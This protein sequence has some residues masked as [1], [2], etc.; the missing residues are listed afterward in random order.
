MTLSNVHNRETGKKA[1]VVFIL[2]LFVSLFLSKAMAQPGAIRRLQN[3]GGGFGGGGKGDSLQKRKDDSITINF[4]FLDSSRLQKFDSSI[5]DF[6]AKINMPWHYV[7][8]GNLGNA[9]HSLIFSPLMKSGWDHGFHSYDPYNFTVEGTRF[10]TT[11]SQYTELNYLIGARMEQNIALLH[12]QNIQPNWNAS[13]QYRLMN[14]PGFFMNQAVNHNNYR[15]G[16]WYQSTNKRYQNFVVIVGNKL[17][18][19]ENGG[20]RTDINYLDSSGY[21]ERFTIPTKLGGD[22]S[23]GSNFFNLPMN[24][25][26]RYTNASYLM[27]QQYDIGQKDSIVTDTTVIPLFYPR[28]RLEHTIAYNT[29]KYRFEDIVPDSLYYASTYKIRDLKNDTSI[30]R[31]RDFWRELV[32]DFSVYQF[33]DAKNPQQFVKAGITLQNLSGDFSRVTDTGNIP[34]P[35][36]VNYYNLFIHGEYRNKTRNQKWDIEANGN[37]YVNGLN[38]GN[39]NAYI[40]LR[41][42][43][44]KKIGYLQAGFHNTNRTP[45]FNFDPMSSFYL[46]NAKSLNNENITRIFGSIEQPL[47]KLKLTGSYYLVS[48]YTY[49]SGPY[50]VEQASTLFNILQ[51]TAEKQFRIGGKWN[52]RT[53]IVLQQKAGD[54]KVNLPLLFTR[55]QL[56][57]DG[58]LGFKNL[59]ISFGLEFRYFTPYKADGYSPL[60]GQFAYQDTATIRMKMPEIAA[61]AHFRIKSFTA[62]VRLENLNSFKLSEGAFRNNNILI[63]DYPS[64]GLQFRL[65]IFWS[66]IN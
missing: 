27:R 44:S 23:A 16:S 12:T 13:V 24:S 31:A 34:A 25:A 19:A 38:A 50:T 18:S 52:W 57:Y 6:N 32:N 51:I 5:I 42:L 43:L 21:T 1:V 49:I 65:G 30:Y 58:N 35:V 15:L 29:Y 10:Y 61:Y 20:I 64:P 11:T 66:F 59:N 33:P 4:R 56:G 9:S 47:Y 3:M 36:K 41:R 22:G 37:F 17:Q 39:Y 48:N 46:D 63:P 40:S 53:W 14:S 54:A 62:Y 8:L 60:V 55:N 7:H 28:L 45:S 26:T 2:L